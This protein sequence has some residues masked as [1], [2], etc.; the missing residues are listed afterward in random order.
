MKYFL[1][2]LVFNEAQCLVYGLLCVK[3]LK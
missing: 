2:Q 3:Q 1:V